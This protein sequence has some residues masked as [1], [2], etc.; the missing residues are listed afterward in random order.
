VHIAAVEAVYLVTRRAVYLETLKAVY[1]VTLKAV[2]L[3]T[4]W[5][6]SSLFF[7]SAG[8][9]FGLGVKLPRPVT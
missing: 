9:N 8:T 6:N 2:H 4:G 7:Y 3:K 1:L 5:V